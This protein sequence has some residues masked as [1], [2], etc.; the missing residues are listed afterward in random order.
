MHKI[1]KKIKII[2]LP[3]SESL[4]ETSIKLSLSSEVNELLS[5]AM[6]IKFILLTSFVDV[7]AFL[8]IFWSTKVKALLKLLLFLSR[9]CFILT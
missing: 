5:L 9:K 3:A 8:R 1:I 2:N 6:I 7:E 4:L